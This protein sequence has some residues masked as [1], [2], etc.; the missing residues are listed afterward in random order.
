MT[1][2]AKPTKPAK[3][4]KQVFYITDATGTV[5]QRPSSWGKGRYLEPST[6]AHRFTGQ[7]ATPRRIGRMDTLLEKLETSL[8]REAPQIREMATQIRGSRPYKIIPFETE[9]T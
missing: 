6:T 7:V 3:R 8:I 9:G 4:P 2:T 1:A 5:F